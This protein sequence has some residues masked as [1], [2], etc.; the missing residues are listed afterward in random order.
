VDQGTTQCTLGASYSTHQANLTVALFPGLRLQSY[1]TG[2]SDVGVP[3]VWTWAHYS[4][5]YQD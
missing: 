3:V 4:S 1:S 5:G 2:R